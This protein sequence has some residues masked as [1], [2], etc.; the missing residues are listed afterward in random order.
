MPQNMTVRRAS[1]DAE[2][3]KIRKKSSLFPFLK[4][5]NKDKRQASGKFC[6][7]HLGICL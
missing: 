6:S 7:L 4:S 3:G 2:N 5:K 1:D